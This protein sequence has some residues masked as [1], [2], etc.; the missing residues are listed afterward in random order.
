[1]RRWLVMGL[2]LGAMASLGGC[3]ND[4]AIQAQ[5]DAKDNQ[6]CID[7]GFTPGNEAYGNCRLKLKQIRA[8]ESAGYDSSPRVGVGVGFGFGH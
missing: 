1:M 2:L 8:E 3:V 5:L 6:D 7:L 4:A